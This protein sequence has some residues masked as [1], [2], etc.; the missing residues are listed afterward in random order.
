MIAMGPQRFAHPPVVFC[1]AEI[2]LVNALAIVIGP[3]MPLTGL[4]LNIATT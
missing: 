2:T 4:L 1:F 3:S